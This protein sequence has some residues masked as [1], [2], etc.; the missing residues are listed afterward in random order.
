MHYLGSTNSLKNK[1][2][3]QTIR[4]ENLKV[5]DEGGIL[6]EE[7]CLFEEY[8]HGVDEYFRAHSFG[9]KD[10][11]LDEKKKILW[12]DYLTIE[13]EEEMQA[14]SFMVND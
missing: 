7:C 4:K 6:M 5:E 10:D 2:E 12:D 11:Y 13:K 1:I 3:D 9:V 8:S 14:I